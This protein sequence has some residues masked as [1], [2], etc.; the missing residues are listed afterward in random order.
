MFLAPAVG[1]RLRLSVAIRTALLLSLSLLMLAATPN[2]WQIN[3]RDANIEEF[4]AQVAQITGKTFVIDPR[5]KGQKVTVIASVGLESEAVYA[6]LLSVLRVHG[7]AAVPAGE[8]VK[9][10]QQSF[11]KHSAGEA[12]L[13]ARA[14]GEALVTRVIRPKNLAV[15]ELVKVLR[16]LI[17]QYSHIASVPRSNVV[18]ISDHLDNMERLEHIIAALDVAEEEVVEVVHL[19]ETWVGDVLNM[20]ERLAPDWLS[21]KSGPQR[22]HLV[23]NEH[24]N[25]LV[26]RGKVEVIAKIRSLIEKIDQ[27]S[28]QSDSVRVFRLA[29]AQAEDLAPIISSVMQREGQV[30]DASRAASIHADV[31]LN[32]LVVRANSTVTAEIQAL[33]ESLDVRRSQVLIEAAIVEVS[34]VGGLSLGVEFAG[35]DADGSSTPLFSTATPGTSGQGL[36]GSFLTSLFGTEG[37]PDGGITPG[38]VV[39]AAGTA[40]SPTLSIFRFSNGG[41][42]FGA[43]VQALST[44]D[45]SNLLS[46]PSIITLDNEEAEIIVGRNVP[47]RTGS[48]TTTTDGVN[49]PFNTI[50]RQDVG[51][52]LRVK[53]NI[54]DD[55]TLRLDVF[56]EVSGIDTGMAVGSNAASDLVTTKRTVQTSILAE[57]QETIILGGLINDDL[58]EKVRKVPLLGSIPILGALFRSK[59]KT[60]TKRNLLIFLRPTVLRNG[61]EARSLTGHKYERIRELFLRG[62][63]PED[64]TL[65]DSTTDGEEAYDIL[66]Q[67]KEERTPQE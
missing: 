44:N 10:I 54:S 42:S 15:D 35:G 5:I 46:T 58:V 63:V 65:L 6:L 30:T 60:R 20:L 34:F 43:I 33:V 51:I 26:L 66:Y 13:Q 62:R 40:S 59:T 25:S 36:I 47:F 29:Y 48:F 64:Q 24:D 38:Q 45:D 56:Q 67:G 27:P 9:I 21:D 11:A 16:P 37:V 55:S 7:F 32:A 14:P 50:D 52:T 1:R 28:A 57:D 12:D 17:P 53:P 19:Q 49:N 2:Q 39:T 23:A 4:I 18:L 22:V 61:A 31:S 8:I 41:I 3:V